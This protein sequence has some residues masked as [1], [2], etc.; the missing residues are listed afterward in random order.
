MKSV[1]GNEI[2]G[3]LVA[4]QSLLHPHGST[5]MS[6][7]L[8]IRPANFRVISCH[9]LST[10]DFLVLF[11][12]PNCCEFACLGEGRF[13]ACRPKSEKNCRKICVGL[14]GKIGKNRPKIGK[15][16]QKSVFGPSFLFLGV[17]WAIFAI[18]GCFFSIFSWR[19]QNRFFSDFFRFRA[20]SPKLAFSQARKLATQLP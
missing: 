20:A 3:W 18:L 17:F 13:R 15:M 14:T 7:A 19:G 9:E 12:S 8:V 5:W 2:S 10:S 16:A 6:A 1:L 4:R 11:C